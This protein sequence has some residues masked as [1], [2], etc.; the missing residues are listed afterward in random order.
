MSVT[1]LIKKFDDRYLKSGEGDVKVKLS[2]VD[3]S[4]SFVS[5]IWYFMLRFVSHV[6]T[7]L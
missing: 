3:I 7:D 6:M 2:F 4:V 5:E 1:W